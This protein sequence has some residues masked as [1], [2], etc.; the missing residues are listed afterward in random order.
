MAN[1]LNLRFPDAS[2]VI[3]RLGADNESG[4]TAVHH[5]RFRRRPP[6]DPVVC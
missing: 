2:H 3:V 4:R 1:E 6:Q 5:T